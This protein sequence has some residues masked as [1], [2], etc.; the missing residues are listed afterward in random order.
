MIVF[1]GIGAFIFGAV[2]GMFTQAM[3]LV[4]HDEDEWMM[5]HWRERSDRKNEE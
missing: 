1:V 4:A 5:K 3:L 2:L